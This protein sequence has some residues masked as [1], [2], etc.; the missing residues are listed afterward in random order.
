MIV[1]VSSVSAFPLT[2]NM[3]TMPYSFLPY[4][5]FNYGGANPAGTAF[6]SPL[7]TYY[8][9]PTAETLATHPTPI[10]MM[11]YTT[12]YLNFASPP[13]TSSFSGPQVPA[14]KTNPF[15]PSAPLLVKNNELPE[16]KF[17]TSAPV[18]VSSAAEAT[19][20]PDNFDFLSEI[21]YDFDAF[22]AAVAAPESNSEGPTAAMI[23]Y[24]R[25][26]GIPAAYSDGFPTADAATL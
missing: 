18:V 2:G 5:S 8:N 24:A 17:T 15:I 19:E 22:L 14:V 6:L 9:L 11:P 12:G 16:V 25:K 23:E 3:M 1:V 10:R 21:N 20:E 13:M 4:G 7:S 26:Y